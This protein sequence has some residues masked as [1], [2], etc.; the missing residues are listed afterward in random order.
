MTTSNQQIEMK[1]V[2]LFQW[3][4]FKKNFLKLLV[5]N[6][7]D[8]ANFS[9]IMR[10]FMFMYLRMTAENYFCYYN[11]KRAGLLSLRTKKGTDA[12]IFGVAVLPEFRKKGLGKY[13]MDFSEKRAKETK[14]KFVALAVLNSNEPAVNLYKKLDYKFVGLGVT[15]ISISLD[16]ITKSKSNSIKLETIL[17]YTDEIKNLFSDT[18]LSQIKAVSQNDGVEYVGENRIDDYHKNISKNISKSKY[19]FFQVLDNNEQIGFLFCRNKGTTKSC[20]VYLHSKTILTNELL[21]YLAEKLEDLIEDN[22]N[23]EKLV[24]RIYCHQAAKLIDLQDS[25]FVR[26]STLDKNLMY[27]KI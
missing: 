6:D 27:K 16:K 18:V 22:E 13:I 24:F 3:R 1:G 7:P 15:P 23:F 11:G 26:D 19:R 25:D 14:K 10:F 17:V 2:N 20:S 5:S 12:F 9:L 21:S 8:I 4:S